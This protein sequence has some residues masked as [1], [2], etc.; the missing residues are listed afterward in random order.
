MTEMAKET[1]FGPVLFIPGENRGRYPNCHSIYI[2]GDKVLIDPASDRERLIQLRKDPGVE[3]VWLTH[4]HEDHFMHLDLFDDIPLLIS[5]QD[6][7]PLSDLEIFMDAYGM[8]DNHAREYWRPVLEQ[9]FH[10]KPRRPKHF[11]RVGDVI[12]LKS[13]TVEVIGTPGHTPGH[14]S[15]FFPGPEVL[16][17]GDY[18]LTKFGPW[19]GD[20]N[21]SI[22]E[23]INSVERLRKVPARVWLA[24]H[25]TGIFEEEPGTIWD[26]YLSV[27]AEREG[28]LIDLLKT[29]RTLEQIVAAC[30][31]YGRPREPK[32]FFELGERGHMKKHLE[33]LMKEGLVVKDGDYYITSQ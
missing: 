8:G 25:E 27:I 33:K 16:L 6:A 23:T 20:L 10:F 31:V 17:L 30:I 22:R 13:G 32:M 2:E 9:A 21:S 24:S 7:P 3:A 18:D 28:K 5:E 14:V 12:H 1:H 29:P 4:W 11:L 15:F 26:K 19:Y